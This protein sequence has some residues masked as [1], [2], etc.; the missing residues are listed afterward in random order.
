[1]PGPIAG[2]LIAE[3]STWQWVFWSTSIF[4]AVIQLACVLFVRGQLPDPREASQ[5]TLTGRPESYAPVLL[6]RR[7]AKLTRQTGR[8]H[9]TEYDDDHSASQT[10][11]TAMSRPFRFLFTQPIIQVLAGAS[12]LPT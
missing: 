10:M 12:P 5:E 9:R 1:V 4:S 2:G 3:Y 6:Q 8:L 11:A 7:A